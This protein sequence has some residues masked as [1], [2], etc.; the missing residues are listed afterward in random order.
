MSVHVE[1]IQMTIPPNPCLLTSDIF[2]K[3][4]GTAIVVEEVIAQ[5]VAVVKARGIRCHNT[6]CH[7]CHV[8]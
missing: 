6:S 1:W 2:H 4:L 7:D 8:L 3:C 5:Q